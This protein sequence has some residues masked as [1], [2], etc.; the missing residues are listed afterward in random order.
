MIGEGKNKRR[1]R[2]ISSDTGAET[3]SKISGKSN[4]KLIKMEASIIGD[5]RERRKKME[6]SLSLIKPD[7]WVP[8]LNHSFHLNTVYE[9][10][11]TSPSAGA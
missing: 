2:M 6:I 10:R 8:G 3:V 11:S 9:D 1:S 7:D 5:S 4:K